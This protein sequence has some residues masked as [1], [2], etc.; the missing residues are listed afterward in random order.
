MKN[1]ARWSSIKKFTINSL[2]S[3]FVYLNNKLMNCWKLLSIFLLVVLWIIMF[4]SRLDFFL[5][6]RFATC[7]TW[8]ILLK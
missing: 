2:N 5:S 8:V 1:T 4:V 6:G 7:L 3:Y